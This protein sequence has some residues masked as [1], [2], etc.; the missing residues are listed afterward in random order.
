M[1][2]KIRLA[3]H[4]RKRKPYYYIVATDSRA[5]RDGSYIER[6][7]SYN[8][9]TDPAT[10]KLDFDKALDWLMKG[11]QPTD[12]CRSILSREGVMMKK[13]L[14]EGV[15]KGAFDE[16]EAERRFDLWRK[17]KEQKMIAVLD[18]MKASADSERKERLDAEV[19]IKETRAQAIAAKYAAAIAPEE[20]ESETETAESPVDEAPQAEE[21]VVEAPVEAKPEEEETTTKVE[22]VP[23]E[24]PVVEEAKPESEVE[25]K[26]EVD[27][28]EKKE[29]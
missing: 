19:K 28:E 5:P 16:K 6:I 12:T 27:T 7:G 26:P 9:T 21:P 14:I 1:P 13:H 20:T 8:P 2:V 4:G 24:D 25:A 29:D 22:E 23:A 18:K 11:A 15:K 10:I 17:D 3:R